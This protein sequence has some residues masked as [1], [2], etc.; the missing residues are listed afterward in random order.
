MS[1]KNN[2]R[3]MLVGVLTAILSSGV[4]ADEEYEI[5]IESSLLTPSV[6]WSNELDNTGKHSDVF[7]REQYSVINEQVRENCDHIFNRIVR[8]RCRSD[9]TDKFRKA[10]LLRGSPEFAY[11]HY[12]KLSRSEREKLA[13]DLEALLV[14][15]RVNARPSDGQ[16]SHIDIKTE[17]KIIKKTL[18]DEDVEAW[19]SDCMDVFGT[20]DQ[21]CK[22][23][24]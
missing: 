15:A 16:L 20:D 3:L 17:L 13:R 24:K 9:V 4:M 23:D 2:E 12:T 14:V 6:T 10:G 8:F 22:I 7:L 11:S 18:L 1:K 5:K 19:I 21:R